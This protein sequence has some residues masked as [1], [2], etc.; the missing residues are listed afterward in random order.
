MKAT[1]LHSWPLRLGRAVDA[2]ALMSNAEPTIVVAGDVCIDWFGIPV[3]RFVETPELQAGPIANWRLREGL[4]MFARP[5]G[6]WLLADLVA[7]AAGQAVL[8]QA[9]TTPL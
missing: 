5:G 2:E 9:M 4:R 7:S 8:R 3:P 1:D 6:A